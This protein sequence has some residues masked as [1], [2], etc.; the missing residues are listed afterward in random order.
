MPFALPA[1][2]WLTAFTVHMPGLC[3]LLTRLPALYPHAAKCLTAFTWLEAVLEVPGSNRALNLH[4]DI[5]T[6]PAP[7]SRAAKWLTASTVHMPREFA[8]FYVILYTC[9]LA[10]WL[11][12][13]TWLEA[14]LEVP[15]CQRA[16]TLSSDT[17]S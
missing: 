16:F 1:A 8:P 3:S 14:M 15:M 4:P 5:C 7:A 6:P 13:V 2:K 17:C 11:T 12:V 9:L 10:Q